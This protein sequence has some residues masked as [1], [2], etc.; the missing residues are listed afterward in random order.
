MYLYAEMKKT[1]MREKL[2]IT[3]AWKMTNEA[4]PQRREDSVHPQ[5]TTNQLCRKKG[6]YLL[7][8]KTI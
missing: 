7:S 6:I 4:R 1:T 3:R 2:K 8:Q 5:W